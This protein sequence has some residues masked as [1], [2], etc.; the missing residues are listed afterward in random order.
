MRVNPDVVK[1]DPSRSFPDHGPMLCQVRMLNESPL[2]PNFEYLEQLISEETGGLGNGCRKLVA[3]NKE[4][5]KGH[6]AHI[7]ALRVLAS[8]SSNLVRLPDAGHSFHLRG[9]CPFLCVFVL[10]AR[11][12]RREALSQIAPQRL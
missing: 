3:H 9:H 4:Y 10:L 6:R 7:D 8:A 1:S 11:L 2:I 5:I 12:S